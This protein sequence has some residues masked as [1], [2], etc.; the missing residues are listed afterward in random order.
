M[1]RRSATIQQ[2]AKRPR[3]PST[4]LT[5]SSWRPHVRDRLP[6]D[7]SFGG[8]IDAYLVEAARLGKPLR[9]YRGSIEKSIRPALGELPA[10]DVTPTVLAAWVAAMRQANY[11]DATI[12]NRL[13]IIGSICRF[14]C[15][16]GVLASDPCRDIPNDSGKAS[17]IRPKYSTMT[18][19][20]LG[21]LPVESLAADKALLFLWTT[22]SFT[23]AAYW[24]CRRWGFVP[25]AQLIWVKGR[26]FDPETSP[27]SLLLQIG[28]GSYTR[29]AHELVIVGSRGGATGIDR[30]I[31]SVFLA[32]RSK[33]SQKPDELLGHVER[34]APGPYLELFARRDREGWASW[35]NEIQGSEP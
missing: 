32:E 35:G 21:N 31:P 2:C 22:P 3:A 28:M 13:S 33:H 8:L 9:A 4:T 6:G 1:A 24:L 17:R 25:K 5:Q 26:I 19:E 15:S 7:I 16:A 29:N 10:A 30:S 27:P 18:L 11:W 34:L 14:G 20:E 23:E 12:N